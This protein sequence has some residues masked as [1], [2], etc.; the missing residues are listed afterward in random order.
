MSKLNKLKD[1]RVIGLII[2]STIIASSVSLVFLQMYIDT[3]VQ[4]HLDATTTDLDSIKV[5]DIS[6]NLT[7]ILKGELILKVGL[8]IS[9][10]NPYD[11]KI[12]IYPFIVNL[13]YGE[14]LI[15]NVSIPG[16]VVEERAKFLL[17][18]STVDVADHSLL[19]YYKFL[20]DFL[21]KNT[22]V[23][24]VATGTIQLETPA[25]FMIVKSTG[26]LNTTIILED[27]I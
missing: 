11:L 5:R 1:I 9:V 4:R 26:F 6:V 22:D 24:I 19:F 20:Y 23:V 18:N 12:T 25:L 7:S 2:V 15:G 13:R 16:F 21:N 17:L 14:S 27:I 3:E 8:N 10:E